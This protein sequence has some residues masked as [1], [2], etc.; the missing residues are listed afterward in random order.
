EDTSSYEELKVFKAG[1]TEKR[2]RFMATTIDETMGDGEVAVLFV[3][4]YHDVHLYLPA[5]IAVQ[6][7]KE[8]D[9][10]K[11]YFE[12]LASGRGEKRFRQLARYLRSP[13]PAQ[14]TV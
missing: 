13:V 8:R 3:G 6:Q 1:L 10:V 9:R 11:A 12:E 5:D 7:L 2:D 14:R 4:A